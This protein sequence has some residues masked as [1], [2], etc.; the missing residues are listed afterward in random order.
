[1]SDRDFGSTLEAALDDDTVPLA[2]LVYLDF[3]GGA[4]RLWTGVGS[5]SYD[6]ETWLGAGHLGSIDKVA[7][8]LEKDDIGVE[9]TLDYL[10]D[11]L[12]N[13][14]VTNDPIGADAS[15]YMA[16]MASDGTVSEAYEIFPGFIDEITILDAGQSGAI[17][18]RLASEL[19]RMA[20][21]L[22]FNLTDAHQQTLF[23]GDKGCEYAARMNQPILWGRKT[24][25]QRP[26]GDGDTGR[27]PGRPD[28]RAHF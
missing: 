12:R 18:V 20:R 17:K 21:P 2:F 5:L 9:L 3:P 22:S 14:V 27:F 6:S 13:E 19:A 8:S 16:L 4:V 26:G 25:T 28:T 10:D 24:F 15:I 23:P 7:D 1:M 11:D